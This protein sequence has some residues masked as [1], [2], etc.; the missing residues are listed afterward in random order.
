MLSNNLLLI[1]SYS[2]KPCIPK[3]LVFLSIRLC[4]IL[5]DIQSRALV[6]I[7]VTN[8]LMTIWLT[9]TILSLPDF[10][11]IQ[12]V[13]HPHCWRRQCCPWP[14]SLSRVGGRG[15]GRLSRPPEP[16]PP[17]LGRGC[18]HRQNQSPSH[19]ENVEHWVSPTD[20]EEVMC[21]L[22]HKSEETKYF[23]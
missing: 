18:G 15:C 11:Q 1:Y 22:E 16:R 8:Y 19:P 13:T 4:H 17:G 6:C 21:E 2:R 9:Q 10:C 12:A 20:H 7:F 3:C 23:N 5:A 14:G